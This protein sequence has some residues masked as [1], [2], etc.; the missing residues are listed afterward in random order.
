MILSLLNRLSGMASPA[1]IALAAMAGA[2]LVL[3]GI[4]LI[5]QSALI[6]KL[7]LPFFAVLKAALIALTA[8]FAAL[9]DALAAL[10]SSFC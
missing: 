2:M 4:D 7:M 8:T 1:F 6:G 10:T 3:P 5:H 9:A